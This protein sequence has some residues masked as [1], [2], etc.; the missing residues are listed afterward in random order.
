MSLL[1]TT[2]IIRILWFVSF[3]SC[4][5]RSLVDISNRYVVTLR[6]NTIIAEHLASVGRLNDDSYAFDRVSHNFTLG[7]FRG[8]A[9][10][11]SETLVAELKKHPDVITVE[12]DRVWQ[13]QGL[14]RQRRSPWGL[15]SISHRGGKTGCTYLYESSAGSG[16]YGYVVDGGIRATHVDL[17]GRVTMGYNAVKDRPFKDT[18]GHGTHVASLMCGTL[19]GVAKKCNLIAVKVTDAGGGSGAAVVDGYTWAF[20]DIVSKSRQAKAVINVSISGHS[21]PALDAAIAAAYKQGVST[22]VAAGN[23]NIDARTVSPASAKGAIAVAAMNTRRGRAKTSN[24][25]AD[26]AVFA[27]GTWVLG[28]DSSTDG[29]GALRSGTSMAAAYVSGLVLYFKGIN[30]LKDAAVTREYLIK[31]AVQGLVKNTAGSPNLL[32]YNGCGK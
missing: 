22:V 20:N 16:T 27:P 28:A 17:V 30:D 4:Y 23:A 18:D 14:E 19:F 5:S 26:V 7:D 24:Y 3:A 12:K 15:H 9:G 31:T 6:P 11:F 13:L 2:L 25:G 32:A 29:A 1:I 21:F 10:H 8:Y